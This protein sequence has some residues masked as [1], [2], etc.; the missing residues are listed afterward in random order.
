MHIPACVYWKTNQRFSEYPQNALFLEDG[1]LLFLEW[2]MVSHKFHTREA[3]SPENK[4]FIILIF[5][6]I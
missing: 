2:K 3:S 5:P 6:S 4:V 1:G